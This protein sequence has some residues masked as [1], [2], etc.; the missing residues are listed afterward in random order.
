[1]RFCAE[2]GASHGGASSDN[3]LSNTTLSYLPVA[4]IRAMGKITRHHHQHGKHLHGPDL[5][6]VNSRPK[7][8]KNRGNKLKYYSE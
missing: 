2:L 6:C 7:Q 3:R 8:Q 1:M 5:H 4:F